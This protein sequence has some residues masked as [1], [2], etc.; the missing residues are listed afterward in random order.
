MQAIEFETQIANE[1]VHLPDDAQVADGQQIRVV[2]LY[3]HPAQTD[4][5]I[6]AGGVQTGAIA[7]LMRDPFRLSGF[8]PL[9]RD[10]AHDS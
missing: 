7:R 10:E 6:S 5:S 4:A 1:S 9:S 8:T 3:Q 2:V